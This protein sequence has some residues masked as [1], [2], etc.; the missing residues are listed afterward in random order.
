MMGYPVIGCSVLRYGARQAPPE[1]SSQR[2]VSVSPEASTRRAT[3][4]RVDAGAGGEGTRATTVLRDQVRTRRASHR[5]RRSTAIRETVSQT[6]IVL[7]AADA[8][9]LTACLIHR[10]ESP[11]GQPR[12][13]YPSSPHRGVTVAV[14]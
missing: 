14:S 3:P 9:A 5:P 13:V 1:R 6:A 4:S 8:R 12:F 11:A 2:R 7:L 10:R